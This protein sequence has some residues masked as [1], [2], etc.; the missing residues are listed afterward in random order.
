MVV[1]MVMVKAMVVMVMVEAHIFDACV[2]H[3]QHTHCYK[4][5]LPL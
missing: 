3:T 2:A 5:Q 1:V 4:K